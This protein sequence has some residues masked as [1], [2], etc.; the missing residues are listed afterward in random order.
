MSH[1]Y[2]YKYLISITNS[3]QDKQCVPKSTKASHVVVEPHAPQASLPLAPAPWLFRQRPYLPQPLPRD[4]SHLQ[5]SQLPVLER[6]DRLPSPRC[7]LPSA[8]L[9]LRLGC[10][11]IPACYVA[12]ASPGAWKSLPFHCGAISRSYGNQI[13]LSV[14]VEEALRYRKIA[15]LIVHCQVCLLQKCLPSVYWGSFAARRRGKYRV[16]F[17]TNGYSTC[18]SKAV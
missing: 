3:K 17:V 16:V 8:A 12:S 18:R 14:G 6:Q 9:S 5:V 13:L 7:C 4:T 2:M 11:A 1:N 10:L 15:A